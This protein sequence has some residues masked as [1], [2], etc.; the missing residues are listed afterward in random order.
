VKGWIRIAV[1]VLAG[2]G[3]VLWLVFDQPM[4]PKKP[5]VPPPNFITKVGEVVDE[6][7]AEKVIYREFTVSTQLRNVPMPDPG[8]RQP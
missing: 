4:L 1:L 7:S 2:H 8:V 5:R 3:S 6:A